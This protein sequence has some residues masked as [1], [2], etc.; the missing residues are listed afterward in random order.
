MILNG[1]LTLL[2]IFNNINSTIW[3]IFLTYTNNI[4]CKIFNIISIEQLSIVLFISI[5]LCFYAILTIKVL[6][7][8]PYFLLFLLNNV[9]LFYFYFLFVL[10]LLICFLNLVPIFFVVFMLFLLNYPCVNILFL[11]G[12]CL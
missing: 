5:Y 9:I 4:F 7:F 8:S 3:C 11:N 6:F 12:F 2:T 10:F 1:I